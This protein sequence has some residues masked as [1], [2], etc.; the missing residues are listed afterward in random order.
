MGGTKNNMKFNQFKDGSCDIVFTEEE[1]KIIIE[2]GKIYLSPESLR[3][4]GN[5]LVKIVAE[6]NKNFNEELA[7]TP[8]NEESKIEGIDRNK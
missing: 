4:F 5:N 3:H 2:K 7:K 8:S 1:K 6:W